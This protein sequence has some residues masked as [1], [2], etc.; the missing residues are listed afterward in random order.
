MSF[1]SRVDRSAFN[2]EARFVPC[3]QALLKA[4]DRART[5]YVDRTG[6][7]ANSENING[8]AKP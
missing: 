6:W 1:E 7:C 2:Q 5:V 3:H 4:L 8:L